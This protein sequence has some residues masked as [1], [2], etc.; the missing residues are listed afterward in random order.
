MTA[1]ALDP[2]GLPPGYPF[3]PDL[4]I[5]PR[6]LRALIEAGRVMLVDCRTTAEARAARIAGA[7]LIPLDELSKQVEQIEED[8]AGRQLVVHCH[9]GGRSMKAA[10]FLRQ[11]GLSAKSLAGGIDLWS[12]DI[13]PTVPRY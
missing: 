7:Q 11:R 12:L 4:E 3:K 9:H 13:D 8:L 10:L 6:D 2:R 1:A 5:T